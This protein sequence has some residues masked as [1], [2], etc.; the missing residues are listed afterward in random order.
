MKLR[1]RNI[2]IGKDFHFEI[3]EGKTYLHILE[4]H[5]VHEN[6]TSPVYIAYTLILIGG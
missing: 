6:Y 2:Q 4:H 5:L 3:G 1:R